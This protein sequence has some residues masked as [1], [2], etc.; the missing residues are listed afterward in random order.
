M[1]ALD[2]MRRATRTIRDENSPPS[3]DHSGIIAECFAAVIHATGREGVIEQIAEGM[4][5]ALA[6]MGFYFP[7]NAKQILAGFERGLTRGR[8]AALDEE[9]IGRA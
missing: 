5:A 4:G 1:K 6:V 3:D 9:G 7:E 2:I 8:D